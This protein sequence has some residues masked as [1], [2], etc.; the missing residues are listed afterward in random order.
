MLETE[1]LLNKAQDSRFYLWLLNRVLR[2]AIPFNAPHKFQVLAI[3]RQQITTGLP[4]RRSNFNHIKGLHACALATIAEFTTGLLLIYIL[5][6][7]KY[8]IIL[9]KLDMQ[10]HY[11]GKMDARATFKISD[12]WLDENVYRPL[13]SAS[14][15]IVVCPIEIHDVEGNHL[16]TGQVHWQLK[17]W[18]KVKAKV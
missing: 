18:E 16:S 7:K 8:R 9:Q 12:N 14:S 15:L 10:Y 3:S 11:Q 13:N 17:T 1:Q 5:G 2:W 4:Y 6:A